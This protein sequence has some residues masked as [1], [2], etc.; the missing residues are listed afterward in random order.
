M[1]LALV[2][3]FPF[4]FPQ[5]SQVFFADQARALQDA[6]ARVTLACYGTGE[7]EPPRDLA[8]VRSPLAPRALRSGP[9]AGKPIADAALAATLLRA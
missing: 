3:A 4:P 6:G 1:H 2:G 9:S 5:G 8:L 7:G